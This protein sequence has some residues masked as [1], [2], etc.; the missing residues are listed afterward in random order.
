MDSG[1]TA[2]VVAIVGVAG[3]LLAP[4]FTQRLIAQVQRKQFEQEQRAAHAT[5]LREQDQEELAYRRSRYVA[6]ISATHHYRN[7]IMNLL[8]HLHRGG[9]IGSALDKL[10]SAREAHHAAVAEAQMVASPAVLT[11]MDFLATALGEGYRKTKS[12]HEGDPDPSGSFEEILDDLL[13]LWGPWRQM[14]SAMRRD[15]VIREAPADD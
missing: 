14:R 7:Q 4:I 10:E 12:L 13:Q 15:L 1:T 2:L 11:E 6:T 8:W 9:A 5:W 3:T